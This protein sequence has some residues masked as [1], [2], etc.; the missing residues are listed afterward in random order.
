ME[1]LMLYYSLIILF[2]ILYPNYGCVGA[3]ELVGGRYTVREIKSL[4]HGSAPSPNHSAKP[5]H[6]PKPQ[7]P[8]STSSSPT[9]KP[10]SNCHLYRHCHTHDGGTI[11]IEAPKYHYNTIHTNPKG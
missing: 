7:P 10:P 5:K 3:R 1:K 11:H 6:K 2:L 8:P 4:T 9:V